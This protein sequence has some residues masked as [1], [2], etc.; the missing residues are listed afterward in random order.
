MGVGEAVGLPATQS[1]ISDYFPPERRATALGIFLLAPP[2][3]AFLGSAGGSWIGQEYGW[4]EAFFIATIL[5]CCSRSPPG[6]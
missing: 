2:I 6:C 5:A 4:R 1:V 3:G